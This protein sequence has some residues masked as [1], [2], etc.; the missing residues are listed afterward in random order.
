MVLTPA[1]P[2]TEIQ[3]ASIET[4][5]DGYELVDFGRGRKLERWGDYLVEYPDRLASGEP[6]SRYWSADWIYVDDVGTR[7]HWQPTRSGL[8]REWTAMIGNLAVPCRLDERGRISGI[9]PIGRADVHDLGTWR[10]FVNCD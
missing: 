2:D 8:A 6:A 9:Q 10:Q 4:P 5:F 3:D 7:G 1:I